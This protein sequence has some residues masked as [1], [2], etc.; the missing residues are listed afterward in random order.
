VQVV[1]ESA[2][3]GSAAV[4]ALWTLILRTVL[5]GYRTVAGYKN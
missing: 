5:A 4:C 2:D 1:T 3:T